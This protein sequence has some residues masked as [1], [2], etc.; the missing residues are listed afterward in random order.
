MPISP[1][2]PNGP[3]VDVNLREHLSFNPASQETLQR[4]NLAKSFLEDYYKQIPAR[5]TTKVYV[6]EWIVISSY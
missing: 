2:T 1:N 5:G 3:K 6:F 4:T